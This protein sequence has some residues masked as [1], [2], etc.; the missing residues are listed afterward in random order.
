[1][2]RYRI[3]SMIVDT[4]K[5]SA[6]WDE[7][8]V[9]DGRNHISV[10]TGSQWEHQELF[11]SKRGRYYI[12]HSSDWQGA[13]A[14]AEFVSPQEACRWLLENSYGGKEIP[15]DLVEYIDDVVE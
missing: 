14:H 7:R 8:T 9:F 15:A 6:R 13:R 4:E 10:P 1:M 2:P 3:E 11:R 5:C 12:V